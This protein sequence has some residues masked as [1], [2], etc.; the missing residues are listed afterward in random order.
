MIVG[1]KVALSEVSSIVLSLFILIGGALLLNWWRIAA[2]L[3]MLLAWV[4]YFFRDPERAPESGADTVI[5]AP[6]DGRITKIEPIEESR[7]LH[8]RA[9][10]ITIFL[11]IFDVH[12]QRCP[13]PGTVDFIHYEPGGFAP[14]MFSSA[15]KNEANYLGITTVHGPLL[16][17]QMAGLIARRIVCWSNVGD[18]L[19]LGQRFGLVKFGS[20]VDL[21]LPLDTEILVAPGQ[22]V[23]GGQTVMAHWPTP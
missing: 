6:G 8:R 4:F 20:R 16:I 13:Y 21:Y 22:Q 14:A 7:F 12:V 23:Y 15:D 17:T 5:L 10:R 11:S 19:A 18:T 2:L 1:A 9:L 3:A